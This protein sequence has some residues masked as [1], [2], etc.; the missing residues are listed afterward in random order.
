MDTIE[1]YI[2]DGW[3][4]TWT[5]LDHSYSDNEMLSMFKNRSEIPMMIKVAKDGRWKWLMITVTVPD[6]GHYRV[7]QK[8][9]AMRPGSIVGYV[10]ATMMTQ[11]NLNRVAS[12]YGVCPY[13]KPGFGLG[14]TTPEPSVRRIVGLDLEQTSFMRQ[15]N[16]PLPHD[17]LLSAAIVTWDG[18]MICRYTCGYHDVDQIPYPEYDVARVENSEELVR[19]IIEWLIDE[20]PDFVVIHNGYNFDIPRMAVHCPLEYSYLFRNINLGKSGKGM[21]LVI[22]GV[23]IF[24]SFHY[25][26]KLHRS[27]YQSVSLDGLALTLGIGFK[28]VQP[29]VNIDPDSNPN[30]TDMILY[31][32]WDSYLHIAVA[33][34]SKCMREI[35]LMCSVFKSPLVDVCRFITGTMVSNMISSYA[36]EQKMVIDWSPEPPLNRKY[37]GAL[38]IAPT[39]GYHRDVSVMDIAAMYPSIMI[40]ANISP[41]TVMEYICGSGQRSSHSPGPELGHN[42]LWWND[43]NIVVRIDGTEVVIDRTPVGV[44]SAILTHLIKTRKS[45]GKKTEM[46]WTLKI[47]ANSL[48]GAMG[49]TTSGLHTFSGAACVT[50]IGRWLITVIISC[51]GI[52]GFDVL[53]GDTD[54]VFVKPRSA[55]TVSTD[56]FLTVVHRILDFTPFHTIRLEQENTFEHIILIE[57][58][59]YYARIGNKTIIKGMAP[60]RKDRIP[61][62]KDAIKNICAIVCW[63]DVNE[64][65]AMLKEFCAALSYRIKEGSMDLSECSIETRKGGVTLLQYKNDEGKTVAVRKDRADTHTGRPSRDWVYKSVVSQVDSVLNVCNLYGFERLVSQYHFDMGL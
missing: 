49:A 53:Y 41:E 17:P 8:R 58:K 61:L 30:L 56:T 51:A 21:D 29:S 3:C 55:K 64:R 19:W 2:N 26:D 12:I 65:L 16:F 28:A 14:N 15:G 6:Y 1:S 32:I 34:Q 37:E 38:V 24:D 45:V 22:P 47:G 48:Y 40:G 46:G 9:T 44:S 31:N 35:I 43:D 11:Q 4:I 52:M 50:A 20:C 13:T 25:I 63:Q 33:V 10:N 39:R 7:L 27:D 62:V 54:S 57:P 23:T 36:L 60:V 59:L 18:R 42:A 5:G